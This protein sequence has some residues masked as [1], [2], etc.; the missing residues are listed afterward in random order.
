MGRNPKPEFLTVVVGAGK[1]AALIASWVPHP[2]H[3]V[4]GGVGDAP[5]EGGR[6]WHEDDGVM[7]I[8]ASV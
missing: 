4:T 7:A 2:S 6:M 8:Y 1:H 5:K 3:N